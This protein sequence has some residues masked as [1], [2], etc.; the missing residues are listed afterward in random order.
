M[1]WVTWAQHRREALVS[2]LVMVVAGGFLLITG[3]QMAGD[4]EHSGYAA[5]VTAGARAVGI[6]AAGA[7]CDPLQSFPL[8]W[9]TVTTGALLALM[10]LPAILGVFIAAPLLSR[11][12]E[13]RTNFLAWS[14]SITPLRWAVIKLALVVGC[15]TVAA[16]ALAM[17]VIWWHSPMD[18]AG[19]NG[20]WS[21]FDVEG[22]APVAYAMFAFA[23]GTLAGLLIR[24]VVPAMALT[25]FAFAGVRLIIELLRPHFLQPI[26]GLAMSVRQGSWA[27]SQNYYADAQGHVLSLDQVN[28][29]MHG[30][31]GPSESGLMAYLQQHGVRLLVDYQPP[32]RFWTF[33]LI[34]SAIFIGLAAL[35][36]GLS[37]WWLQRRA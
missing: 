14:Q 28:G 35:L 11:E 37:L 6:F 34:E 20:Q 5:C 23:L 15:M 22:A 36:I 26:T 9:A 31:S 1:I 4:L 8:H 27:I 18:L 21:A 7:A 24:R 19:F 32:E 17:A 30:Y 2:S 25:L 10:A 3:F 16:T 33:Q 12:F 13:Q 29:V